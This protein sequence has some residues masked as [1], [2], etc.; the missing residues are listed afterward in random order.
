[1]KEFSICIAFLTFFCVIFFG[2]SKFYSIGFNIT[3][4]M[5]TGFYYQAINQHTLN[6]NDIIS[7]K[8]DEEIAK[9]VHADRYIN[10]HQKLLKF[11]AG[12][13][14]DKVDII[15]KQVCVTLKSK[16]IACSWGEIKEK[17]KDGN[18]TVSLLKPCIIP[19]NKVL[20][21]ATHRGSFDSRYFGLVDISTI[22]K[23]K[24]F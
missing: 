3:Q 20:A 22:K 7:F 13:P 24:K 11:V 12:L 16:K 21:M 17:D 19:Q 14:G 8:L 15:D 9:K 1:M 18:N 4:S 2:V 10:T 23:M 5:E 6:Y